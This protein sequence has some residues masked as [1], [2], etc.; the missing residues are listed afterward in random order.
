MSWIAKAIWNLVL[1]AILGGLMISM[2]Q[3]SIP[4]III[5]PIIVT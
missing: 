5:N 1:G 4:I 2:G 3:K